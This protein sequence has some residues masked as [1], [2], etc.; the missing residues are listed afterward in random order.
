MKVKIVS[1]VVVFIGIGFA[2]CLNSPLI[3]FSGETSTISED[4]S[5]NVIV[6]NKKDSV[7]TIPELYLQLNNHPIVDFTRLQA[8]KK[9]VINVNGNK[10]QE[11]CLD[12]KIDLFAYSIMGYYDNPTIT[13]R[14]YITYR[15]RKI[16][17]DSLFWKDNLPTDNTFMTLFDNMYKF[18][19]SK[20]TYLALFA[21]DG[22]KS[23]SRPN[24]LV[25]LIDYSNPD[26]ISFPLVDYQAS[27]DINCFGD[28]N[29]DGELDYIKW[30]VGW[31][32]C[33]TV[34]SYSL[35]NGVFTLDKEHYVTIDK[36][37][38]IGEYEIDFR[39]SHWWK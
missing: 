13:Q 21:W 28:F 38:A 26:E 31:E 39:K 1:V 8:V 17:I 3:G 24:F 37:V 36:E 14:D 33:D 34:F 6:N 10:F 15:G 29:S 30:G 9:R 35:I 32:Y 23:T 11:Y 27:E 18:T 16:L 19:L 25:L 22:R 7:F 2:L 20:H 5:Q 4:F 12:E